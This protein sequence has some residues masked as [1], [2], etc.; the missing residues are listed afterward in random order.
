MNSGWLRVSHYLEKYF[1]KLRRELLAHL[2]PFAL[3]TVLLIQHNPEPLFEPAPVIEVLRY[4]LNHATLK[5]LA[6]LIENQ[7]NFFIS[8][9]YSDGQ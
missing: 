9:T 3:C 4:I 2:N 6:I 8:Y 1:N 5:L 7:E